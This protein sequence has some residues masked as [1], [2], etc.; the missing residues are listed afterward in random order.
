MGF[1]A[2]EKCSSYYELKKGEH[3]SDYFDVRCNCGGNLRY[4]KVLSD[5]GEPNKGSRILPK[6]KIDSHYR[7]NKKTRKQTKSPEETKNRYGKLFTSILI[8][9]V[10][11]IFITSG[12]PLGNIIGVIGI[13]LAILYYFTNSTFIRVIIAGWLVLFGLFLF[14]VIRGNIFYNILGI[15]AL[16]FGLYQVNRIRIIETDKAQRKKDVQTKTNSSNRGFFVGLIITILI[17][18]GIF[19]M[20]IVAMPYNPGS[21][22]QDS[23]IVIKVTSTSTNPNGDYTT[24]KLSGSWIGSYGDESG[25]QSVQG[26]GDE[27]FQITGNP[28]TVSATFQKKSEFGPTLTVQ[29][30]KNGVV[31]ETRSTDA[32][33]GVVSVTHSF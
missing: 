5:V 8:V 4:Y 1:L 20:G 25:S 21:V 29:I 27:T 2:C 6:S 16:I 18:G 28:K 7:Q 11:I 19:W 24:S 23:G 15:F 9:G 13:I 32:K 22:T 12:V 3:P 26:S 31:V 33:Y 14:V 30:L 10:S 17:I